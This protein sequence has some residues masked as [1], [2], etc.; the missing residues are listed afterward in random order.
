MTIEVRES[1]MQTVHL[2]LPPDPNIAEERLETSSAG[3]CCRWQGSE[4]CDLP[5]TFAVVWV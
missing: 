1:D 3:L 2:A 4:T 5:P